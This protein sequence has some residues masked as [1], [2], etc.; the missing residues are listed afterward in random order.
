ML[1]D[2]VSALSIGKRV[3]NGC[4]FH[5]TPKNV[6]DPGSCTLIKSDGKRIEL[7]VDEHDLPYL[8][9]HRT[10]ADPAQ[11]QKDKENERPTTTLIAGARARSDQKLR[12]ILRDTGP[13][14]APRG[15]TDSPPEP[16][17]YDY[18]VVEDENMQ[19]LRRR[20]DKE[21]LIEYAKSLTHLCT[22]LPK[23]PYCTSYMRFKVNQEPKRRRRGKKHTVEAC[24]FG[25]S[26]T[27]D[28]LISNGVLSNG[29]DGEAVGFLLRDHATKF[30]Q[31]YHAAT[32]SAKE[33]EIA[34]KRF[35]GPMFSNRILHLYTDG[36]P[37]IVKAGKNLKTCHDTSTPYRSATNGIRS[38]AGD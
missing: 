34:L 5:W 18:S 4:E 26:V 20:G 22:H 29:I 2:S 33:C 9:E 13:V 7:E 27:G 21:F 28:H 1:T 8:L 30:R 12:S 32:E 15:R 24:K 36:A 17:A 23:N 31:L 3:A 11:I 35:Q 6:N 38:R 25:D 10:T 14:P 16:I 37:E 19:D